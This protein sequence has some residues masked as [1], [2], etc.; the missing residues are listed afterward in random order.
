MFDKDENKNTYKFSYIIKVQRIY[1]NYYQTSNHVK[2][3]S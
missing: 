3:A 1:I 2:A